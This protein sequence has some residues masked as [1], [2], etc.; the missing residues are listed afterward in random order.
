MNPRV[1]RMLL[2]LGAGVAGL[3]FSFVVV[4]LINGPTSSPS[5]QQTANFGGPFRLTDQNGKT[6]TDQDLKG[7]PLLVFFGFT[8][9][10]DVCPTTLLEVSAVLRKLA[11]AAGRVGRLFVTIDLERDTA[12]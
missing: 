11:P 10:P 8:H 12:P 6:F 9:C 2:I 3:V 5:V 1:I 4:L 7:P